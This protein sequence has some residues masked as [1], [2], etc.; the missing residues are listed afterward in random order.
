[1]LR[2]RLLIFVLALQGLLAASVTEPAIAQPSA[3]NHGTATSTMKEA[4]GVET[5]KPQEAPSK[6]TGGAAGWNGTYV[7]VNAGMRFGAMARTNV[8]VPFGTD[9]RLATRG[10]LPGSPRRGCTKDLK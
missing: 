7:G 2:R 3:K 8:V 4:G 5:I 10:E 9:G 1:M 6:D